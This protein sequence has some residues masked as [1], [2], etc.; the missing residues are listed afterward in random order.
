MLFFNFPFGKFFIILNELIVQKEVLNSEGI[1][2]KPCANRRD[3]LD[4]HQTQVPRVRRHKMQLLR[5]AAAGGR[6]GCGSSGDLSAAPA[7]L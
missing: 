3:G 7:Q 2:S 1:K 5:V 6:G 4:I